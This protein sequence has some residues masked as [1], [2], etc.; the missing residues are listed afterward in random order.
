MT[1]RPAEPM[2]LEAI[3]AIYNDAVLHTTATFD[4]ELRSPEKQSEWFLRHGE[5]HPVL[6]ACDGERVL[7][8]ASLSPWSDR[9]AYDLTAELSVYVHPDHRRKG[10]GQLLIGEVLRAGQL[11]GLHTVLSRI[12]TENTVSI[13]MHE[14]AGF[15]P[16]GIM[17]EVGKKFGR[18]LDVQM[19]QFLY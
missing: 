12:T 14:V 9:A 10:V 17:K 3:R 5:R 2:D 4:T 15:L 11:A 19:M 1:V 8:W 6:V 13:R 16:I 7:G 18:L